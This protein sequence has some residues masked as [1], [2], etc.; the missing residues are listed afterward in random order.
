VCVDR[1]FIFLRT[2]GSLSLCRGEGA[3]KKSKTEETIQR[4]D[5]NG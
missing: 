4:G 2:G 1:I 3:N 5:N